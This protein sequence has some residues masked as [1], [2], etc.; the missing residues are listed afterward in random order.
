MQLRAAL[1]SVF[2]LMRTSIAGA[3]IHERPQQRPALAVECVG[4]GEVV[5]VAGD[6]ADQQPAVRQQ[7][8]PVVEPRLERPRALPG[9]H[10]PVPD[11]DLFLDGEDPRHLEHEARGDEGLLEHPP[12][13]RS[14][15]GHVTDERELLLLVVTQRQEPPWLRPR[16][17]AAHPHGALD[18]VPN[19]P[20]AS[21]G[22]ALEGELARVARRRFAAAWADQLGLHCALPPMRS[23]AAFRTASGTSLPAGPAARDAYRSRR[24]ARPRSQ[25]GGTPYAA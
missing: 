9:L 6:V 1:P 22:A 21:V 17:A 3:L 10:P 23:G 15:L 18:P 19:R 5:Q 13:H 7:P 4:I 25:T 12:R 8:R 24:D 16:E 14:Q 2:F 20:H 11:L